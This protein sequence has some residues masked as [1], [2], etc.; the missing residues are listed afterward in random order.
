MI[1]FDVALS[2]AGEQRPYVEQVATIIGNTGLSIFYD[3]FQ[4]S[5]LWGKDLSI[6]LHDVYS[7][8]SK[9]CIMFISKEYVEKFWP[10]HEREAALQKQV[11]VKGGYI[12]PVRFDDT[13][14]PG[15]PSS[16]SYLDARDK[17]PKEIADIFLEKFVN[18]EIASASTTKVVG[19][20]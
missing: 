5:H 13:E 15:L 7:K 12:L 14:I 19:V 17:S 3:A 6:Y 1:E 2:F 18:P 10:S 11:E 8:K 16:I 4:E 20:I 9:F